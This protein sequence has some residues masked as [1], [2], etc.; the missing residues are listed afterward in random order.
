MTLFCANADDPGTNGVGET[1]ARMYCAEKPCAVGVE[2]PSPPVPPVPSV[3]PIPSSELSPH[4]QSAVASAN[5]RKARASMQPPSRRCQSSAKSL[6]AKLF[7]IIPICW[8]LVR[9]R[10]LISPA[11]CRAADYFFV[12]SGSLSELSQPLVQ[13]TRAPQSKLPPMN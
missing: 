9:I 4:A 11:S 8:R 3:P 12:E 2:P 5:Q 10:R 6:I 7:F 13:I 1:E